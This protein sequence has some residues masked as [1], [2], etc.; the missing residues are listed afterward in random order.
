M[1]RHIKLWAEFQSKYDAR[2]TTVGEYY[3]DRRDEVRI[4]DVSEFIGGVVP[5]A[6]AVPPG[7]DEDSL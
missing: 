3:S 5:P 1:S 7:D 6:G 4:E 2:Y